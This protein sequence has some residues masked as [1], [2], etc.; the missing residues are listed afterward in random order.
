[1]IYASA[2]EGG[3]LS[4]VMSLKVQNEFLSRKIV[5]E[6]RCGTLIKI[7]VQSLYM[8]VQQVY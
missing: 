1:M 5:I 4:H 7:D 3:L 8:A 6:H 2:S